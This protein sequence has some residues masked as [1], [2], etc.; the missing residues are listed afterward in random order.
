MGSRICGSADSS[1]INNNAIGCQKL[2]PNSTEGTQIVKL[3]VWFPPEP[4]ATASFDFPAGTLVESASSDERKA[5][6]RVGWSWTSEVEW[7]LRCLLV[8]PHP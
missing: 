1:S 8:E 2:Q 3:Q 4:I 6:E 7:L 5:S